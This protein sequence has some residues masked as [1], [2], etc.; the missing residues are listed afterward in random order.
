[1]GASTV[2]V[3]WS[4][5]ILSLLRN[6]GINIPP[7]YAAAPWTQI[8]L[9]DGTT[10]DGIVNIPAALIVLA[11][12]AMLIG[13]TKELAR[14]NNIM[15]AIKLFVVVAFILLGDPL[16]GVEEAVAG[17][18]AA[19]VDLGHVGAEKRRGHRE[20]RQ[21]E[22]ELEPALGGHQSFSGKMS[23]YSRYTV[24]RTASTSPTALS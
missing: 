15:V 2:A 11:L 4:G 24:T 19:A 8:K 18:L 6:F 20:E 23:A 14:L 21:E 13:G 5:Y 22:E 9:P 1:M 3:G 16:D 10:V 7:E 17:G 12:T